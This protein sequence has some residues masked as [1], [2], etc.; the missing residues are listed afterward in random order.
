[1]ATNLTATCRF[2]GFSATAKMGGSGVSN[3]YPQ[4][5]AYPATMPVP[6]PPNVVTN[7]QLFAIF[8]TDANGTVWLLPP[9]ATVW[10]ILEQGA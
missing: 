3:N 9:N 8:Y 6:L 7:P 5:Y 10:I 1:M 4:F 2:T